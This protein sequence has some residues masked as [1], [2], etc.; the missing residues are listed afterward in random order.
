MAWPC[1]TD[2]GSKNVEHLSKSTAQKNVEEHALQMGYPSR[3]ILN[4][5]FSVTKWKT[6][7]YFK[8]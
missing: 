6:K 7:L 5:C 1:N 4:R 3:D 8:I 2:T